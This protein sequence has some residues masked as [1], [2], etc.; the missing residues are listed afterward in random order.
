MKNQFLVP[1]MIFRDFNMF[2][3]LNSLTKTHDEVTR[4]VREKSNLKRNCSE[5]ASPRTVVVFPQG[6]LEFR[7][8]HSLSW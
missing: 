4:K 6:N 1:E 8:G 5:E 7:G 2:F 3:L